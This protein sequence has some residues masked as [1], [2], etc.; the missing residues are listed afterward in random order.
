MSPVSVNEQSR[1]HAHTEVNDWLRSGLGSI[2]NV[3]CILPQL[4]HY[5]LTVKLKVLFPE[6]S[7]I[8]I[9]N[10]KVSG[11]LAI[12]RYVHLFSTVPLTW[13]SSLLNNINK[14]WSWSVL[15]PK[16]ILRW[17]W[18]AVLQWVVFVLWGSERPVFIV[19]TWVFSIQQYP[20][21]RGSCSN[22]LHLVITR[23]QQLL[24]LGNLLLAQ[25][26]KFKGNALMRDKL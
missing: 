20:E 12:K 26:L 23:Q 25:S 15:L 17:S 9:L 8:L 18:C 19:Y 10:E 1:A 21:L 11:N 7:G 22:K 3:C 24:K 5:L 14:K 2:W 4:V 6:S 13:N 16:V